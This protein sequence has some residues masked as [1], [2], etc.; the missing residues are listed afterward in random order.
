MKI[1]YI[2]HHNI[3]DEGVSKI[4]AMFSSEEKAKECFDMVTDPFNVEIEEMNIDDDITKLFT[5]SFTMD[6]EGNVENIRRCLKESF[7]REELYPRDN[8]KMFFK[9]HTHDIEKAKDIANEK[10]K[11]M[12]EKGAWGDVDKVGRLF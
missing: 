3:Y 4:S 2:L 11:L 7:D 8:D 9:I 10:R 12:L 5:V 1:Y 6:R